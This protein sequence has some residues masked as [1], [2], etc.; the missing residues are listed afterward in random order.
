MLPETDSGQ[1]CNIGQEWHAPLWPCL[2]LY[3]PTDFM[4]PGFSVHGNF[5]AGVLEWVA[6]S[7]SRA[8]SLAG[9]QTQVSCTS[10]IGRQILYHCAP[11]ISSVQFSRSVVC[12]PLQPHGLQQA[13]PPCPAPTPGVHSNSCPLSL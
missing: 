8:S 6:I 2:T 12:D 13:E 11:G 5:Q 4:F 7:S 9:D 1:S 3:N 10:C